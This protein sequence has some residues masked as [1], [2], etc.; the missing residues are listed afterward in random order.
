MELPSS[1]S[2]TPEEELL[3]APESLPL[4]GPTSPSLK[5]SSTAIL[6]TLAK[7]IHCSISQ[8][9]GILAKSSLTILPQLLAIVSFNLL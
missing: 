7:Y 1:A 3:R 6:L 4:A 5:L 2:I 8:P 9:L